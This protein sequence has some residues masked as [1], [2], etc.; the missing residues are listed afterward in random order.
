MSRHSS[1]LGHLSLIQLQVVSRADMAASDI[2]QFDVKTTG[3]EVL[4]MF[5]SAID[6]KTCKILFF[7]CIGSQPL[8]PHVSALYTALNSLPHNSKHNSNHYS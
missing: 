4:K 6:G 5:E 3:L 8:F 1:D 7:F 2:P